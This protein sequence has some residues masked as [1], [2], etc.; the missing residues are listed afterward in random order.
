MNRFIKK[1]VPFLSLILVLCGCGNSDTVSKPIAD[2]NSATKQTVSLLDLRVAIDH[3]G[4]P[5]FDSEYEFVAYYGEEFS[6]VKLLPTEYEL[7]SQYS[8]ITV[9]ANRITIPSDFA[10]K[11]PDVKYVNIYA[12]HKEKGDTDY[13]PLAIKRWEQTFEDEFET[14][15]K[16]VWSFDGYNPKGEPMGKDEK[17]GENL[18]CGKDPDLPYVRDGNLI[19]S[20]KKGDKTVY[21]QGEPWT[22][23]YQSC[24]I[25][26]QNS[27][28]QQYGC[29]MIYCKMPSKNPTAGCISAFWL[30]PAEGTWGQSFMFKKTGS[31]VLNGYNCGEVDIF[32]YSPAWVGNSQLQ[33]TEHWWNDDFEKLESGP[34]TELRVENDKLGKEYVNVACVWTANG[35]FTY[36]DGKLVK[37]RVSLQ[38]ADQKAYI[39]LSQGIGTLPNAESKSWAGSFTNED[40]EKKTEYAIDWVRAYK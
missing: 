2:T 26:T 5:G 34:M 6:A 22:A 28:A 3:P 36:I 25:T 13:Y 23:D 9:D 4:V 18:Y 12:E 32:E 14:Y 24:T 16:N 33:I 7:K 35:L 19:L 17:T 20:I 11:H 39:L 21:N 30:M 40:L 29:F 38:P 1:F 31:D 15:N 8:E 10:E 37:S 27:F